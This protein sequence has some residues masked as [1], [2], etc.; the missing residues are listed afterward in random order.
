MAFH[1][2]IVK[3]YL[4]CMSG[5]YLLGLLFFIPQSGLF[6]QETDSTAASEVAV[7]PRGAFPDSVLRFNVKRPSPKRAGLYSACLPGLGQLYNRQYLKVGVVYA[8]AAVIGGF[9]VTNYKDYTKY[10]KIYIGMIDSNPNTPDTYQNLTPDDVKYIRDGT[11]RYL[12]YSVI[13]AVAGYMM[14]ILDAFISAHLRTF[15][16]SKDISFRPT[17]L[18]PGQAKPAWQI[19]LCINF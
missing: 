14:N 7:E 17:I 16:I 8:G 11:R 5:L 3:R 1:M 19:G 10:R 9:L 4:K 13:A 15:D 18:Q 6:A 12:E 2:L